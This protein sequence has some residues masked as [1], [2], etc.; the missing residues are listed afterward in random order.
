MY[1]SIYMLSLAVTAVHPSRRVPYA[2]LNGMATQFNVALYTAG[3]HT[4]FPNIP[5]NHPEHLRNV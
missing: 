1:K 2:Q 5:S 3:W 4:S